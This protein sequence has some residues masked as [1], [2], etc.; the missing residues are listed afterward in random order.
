[1]IIV[2]EESN[3]EDFFGFFEWHCDKNQCNVIDPS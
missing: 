2:V 1:M 3:V